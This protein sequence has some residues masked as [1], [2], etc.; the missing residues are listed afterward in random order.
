MREREREQNQK[1]A[2]KMKETGNAIG[3][4]RCFKY[5][6]L[7]VILS[8]YIFSRST[9]TPFPHDYHS[10]P[11]RTNTY[12]FCPF[13]PTTHSPSVKQFTR[14]GNGFCTRYNT[15]FMVL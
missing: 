7:I 3:F 14:S 10:K 9:L 1:N 4:E 2:H 15:H 12:T 8:K 6:I 5:R 13:A 11:N